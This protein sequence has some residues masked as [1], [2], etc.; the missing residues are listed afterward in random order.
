MPPFAV[1]FNAHNLESSSVITVV[2]VVTIRPPVPVKS[3]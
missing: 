2:R 3:A 1:N